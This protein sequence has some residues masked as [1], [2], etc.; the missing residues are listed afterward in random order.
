MPSLAGCSVLPMCTVTHKCCLR[1]FKW[2]K[3]I[4][5][6]IS[7]CT[8][9]HRVNPPYSG[10]VEELQTQGTATNQ[11]YVHNGHRSPI[12]RSRYVRTLAVQTTN[13][14]H[15]LG[16]LWQWPQESGSSSLRL[17]REDTGS[18]LSVAP[19]QYSSHGTCT[20]SQHTVHRLA[21]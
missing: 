11:G 7:H 4:Q 2:M 14:I 12:W 9:I 8:V 21:W 17:F 13:Q 18:G 16:P 1:L 20:G 10:I 19:W 3:P 5:L 15:K 6:P